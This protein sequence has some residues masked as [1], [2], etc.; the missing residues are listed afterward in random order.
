MASKNKLTLLTNLNQFVITEFFVNQQEFVEKL[1]SPDI[2][3]RLGALFG[4]KPREILQDQPQRNISAY[5]F[6]CEDK[7][8]EILDK[9]PGIKP[10]KVMIL[11]GEHWKQ[12]SEE[13][14]RPYIERALKDKLRYSEYLESSKVHN[15]KQVKPSAYNLFCSEERKILKESNPDLNAFEIRNELGRRWKEAKEKRPE[16]LKTKYSYIVKQPQQPQQPQQ[17]QQPQQK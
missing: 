17:S 3:K 12:L 11:F 7:R 1:Q 15:K 2:Q 5:L 4:L 9:N 10:N 16:E 13:E 8:K 14:K 6:F